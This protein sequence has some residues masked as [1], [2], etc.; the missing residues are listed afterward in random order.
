MS[1][2]LLILATPFCPWQEFANRVAESQN[3]QLQENYIQA[4]DE[5]SGVRVAEV[6]HMQVFLAEQEMA[7]PSNSSASIDIKRAI[8]E[9]PDLTIISDP[10]AIKSAAS[11]MREIPTMEVVIFFERP[12]SLISREVAAFDGG[13]L[14]EAWHVSAK[15][16][17]GLARRYR[18]RIQLIDA[19]EAMDD[20]SSFIQKCPAFTNYQSFFPCQNQESPFDPVADAVCA[21]WLNTNAE[22]LSALEELNAFSEVV[23]LESCSSAPESEVANKAIAALGKLQDSPKIKENLKKAIEENE[24]LLLQLHQVQE[25]LEHYF[26]EVR[27]VEQAFKESS[28]GSQAT[29]K[30]DAIEVG[31]REEKAPHRHINFVLREA[32]Q[33]QRSFSK[34]NLRLVEHHGKPG[35]V[36]FGNDQN[37]TQSL[38]HW[39]QHGDEAGRGFMLLVPADKIGKDFLVAA[40]A[41]DLLLVREAVALLAVKIKCH[42]ANLLS[43]H[44]ERVA[45][46][47]IEA[48]NDLPERL[49][50]DALIARSNG[51][52][53]QEEYSFEVTNAWL[54]GR[55]INSLSFVWSPQ[56]GEIK[57]YCSHH[58][59]PLSSWPLNADMSTVREWAVKFLESPRKSENRELWKGLTVLDRFLL[60]K[61]VA[62]LPN[63]IFHLNE[64]NPDLK[65]SRKRLNKSALLL[66][67]RIKIWNTSLQ[68]RSF[69]RSMLPF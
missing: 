20:P 52:G 43:T 31:D 28:T 15:A 18:S 60:E 16:I 27:R 37:T 40:T 64:Q 53:S 13:S 11:L 30:V 21:F 51:A 33:F 57:I 10:R 68:K 49:H 41:S 39:Q 9:R 2:S 29:L 7:I 38:S 22:A 65:I 8:F 34:L 55:L 14:L 61:I 24:L 47:F 69:L 44:W 63:F 36:V 46:R 50:Y 1:R 54:G 67:K 32:T 6:D 17:L 66:R 25:E 58:A 35:I 12:S 42:N 19:S 26:L 59:P 3:R 45:L 23:S 5:W 62:E 4:L 48:L 56:T